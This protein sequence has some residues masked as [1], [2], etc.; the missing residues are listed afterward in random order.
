MVGHCKLLSTSHHVILPSAYGAS[1]WVSSTSAALTFSSKQSLSLRSEQHAV[2]VPVALQFCTS[3]QLSSHHLPCLSWPNSYSLSRLRHQ[4]THSDTPF[5][6][7]PV[8]NIITRNV[9]IAVL[10]IVTCQGAYAENGGSRFCRN[11]VMSTRLMGITFSS[12]TCSALRINS[13]VVKDSARN[14]Q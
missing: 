8:M 1:S 4:V 3:Q 13:N 10:C 7:R 2:S 5:I 9:Q 12:L 11:V 6:S 14:F